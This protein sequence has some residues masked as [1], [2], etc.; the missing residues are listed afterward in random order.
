MPAVGGRKATVRPVRFQV[1]PGRNDIY[2]RPDGRLP[3]GWSSGLA[4]ARARPRTAYDTQFWVTNDDSHENMTLRPVGGSEYV[5]QILS[6][7]DT[8]EQVAF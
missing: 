8:P 3:G 6:V 4:G 7:V 1:A 5:S 2:R